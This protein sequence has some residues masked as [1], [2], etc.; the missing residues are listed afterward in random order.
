MGGD[1]YNMITKGIL[2]QHEHTSQGMFV[3]KVLKEHKIGHVMLQLELW[4]NSFF[5]VRIIVP[6]STGRGVNYPL[7]C[8]SKAEGKR[9][10]KAFFQAAAALAIDGTTLTAQD[11][12]AEA[13]RQG[14]TRGQAL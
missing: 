14:W 12:M 10:F 13:M 5:Y 6:D 4:T 7:P 2:S 11:I 3:L 8:Y 9:A 1:V